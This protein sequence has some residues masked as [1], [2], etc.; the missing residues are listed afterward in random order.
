M[1]GL[2]MQCLVV[3][4]TKNGLLV[5]FRYTKHHP[6]QEIHPLPEFGIL[7][8]VQNLAT[9]TNANDCKTNT[10]GQPQR[11]VPKHPIRLPSEAN[12]VDERHAA[13]HPDPAIPGLNMQYLAV[14]AK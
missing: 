1:H 2:T 9:S 14:I 11:H 13:A 4:D 5:Y 12:T 10:C 7:R 6:P 8:R 3:I